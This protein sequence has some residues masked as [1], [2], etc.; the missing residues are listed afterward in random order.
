MTIA[1]GRLHFVLRHH[2]ADVA[3]ER[4]RREDEKADSGDDRNRHDSLL[5]CRLAY[6]APE[7]DVSACMR[8]SLR[9]RDSGPMLS[10]LVQARDPEHDADQEEEQQHS[11]RDHRVAKP[12]VGVKASAELSRMTP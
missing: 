7:N 6:R 12:R 3:I 4:G 5:V 2:L 1:C 8:H 10:P 11:H 9:R